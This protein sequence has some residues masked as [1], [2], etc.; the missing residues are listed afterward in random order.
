M[1]DQDPLPLIAQVRV[2]L[3]ALGFRSDGR[4]NLTPSIVQRMRA[5]GHL[6]MFLDT[7]RILVYLGIRDS[8]DDDR[9]AHTA[10]AAA[11]EMLPDA[12]RDECEGLLV[13]WDDPHGEPHAVALSVGDDGQ[14]GTILGASWLRPTEWPIVMVDTSI[15]PGEALDSALENV[16]TAVLSDVSERIDATALTRA[17]RLVDLALALVGGEAQREPLDANAVPAGAERTEWFRRYEASTRDE[18][19][20]VHATLSTTRARVTLSTS[21]GPLFGTSVFVSY[22]R[23]D[24]SE[25]ARPVVEALREV[26]ADVWFDQEEELATGWLDEGLAAVI[27]ACDAY[28][29]CA[30]DEFFERARYATQELAWAL[31]QLGDGAL[32]CLV[33]VRFPGTV[34][35]RAVD[36]WPSL[37]IAPNQN[38]PALGSR[39]AEAIGQ[40]PPISRTA[41]TLHRA[42]AREKPPQ[43]RGEVDTDALLLRV[44]HVERLLQ[45]PSADLAD[46]IRSTERNA[47]TR[48]LSDLLR[49]VEG[50]LD[51]DGHLEGHE[52]WSPD[53]LV[54]SARWMLSSM[55][56]LAS[57]P[58]PLSGSLE[59]RDRIEGDFAIILRELPPVAE[60]PD[61]VGWGDSERRYLLRFHL[62]LL[63]VAQEAL[64]TGHFAGLPTDVW[65]EGDE[66]PRQ[67]D[68]RR[69]DCVDLLVDMRLGGK[70]SWQG[71]PV[72]WESMYAAWLA[73]LASPDLS[74][75]L[76]V[77]IWR[78]LSG[79]LRTVAALCAEMMSLRACGGDAVLSGS[80]GDGDRRVNCRCWLDKD[81]STNSADA[82][83][84]SIGLI[85]A[86]G[87]S[88]QVGWLDG[89]KTGRVT[90]PATEELAQLASV[91]SAARSA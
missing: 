45:I 70:L 56:V 60:W 29:L 61:A 78:I 36:R 34:L 49:H 85:E 1:I 74:T 39:I 47:R 83:S 11:L 2:V 10:G 80:I 68:A 64:R 31:Q 58:W 25:L 19:N 67:L 33:T 21:S 51:W 55:R 18:W 3:P 24:S 59:D 30:S 40:A 8:H 88:V 48:R 72:D 91:S 13:V 62:G 43:A 79:S 20:R 89:T 32:K 65:S 66:W 75:Q 63:R 12:I 82:M 17:M 26:G 86:D 84:L 16:R 27:Q 7:T 4:L 35:P 15:P 53:P 14:A 9:E 22:A 23:P 54:R 77:D 28:V 81:D 76:P 73:A 69:R 38:I 41:P 5:R 6:S 90:V 57:L 52:R 46:I 37:D 71:D 44:R 42:R 50:G 87:G